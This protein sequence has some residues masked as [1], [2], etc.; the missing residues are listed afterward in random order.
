MKGSS[1]RR[2]G[3]GTP[4]DRLT[5]RQSE[6]CALSPRQQEILEAQRLR[7]DL[8]FA[9]SCYADVTGR[10]DLEILL[11]SIAQ[12]GS[13]FG[14]GSMSLQVAQGVVMN[15]IDSAGAGSIE[16]VDLRAE[17]DSH[18]AAQQWM[19]IDSVRS[20]DPLTDELVTSA[21]LLLG[22]KR[23]FW[24]TRVHPIV[25]D[26]VGMRSMT[27]R[28]AEI[29]T[30]RVRDQ[31]VP[32]SSAKTVRTPIDADEA[33]R[34]SKRW[35]ADQQ[36]WESKLAGAPTRTSLVADTAP[37][38]AMTRRSG[39]T[40][41]AYVATSLER[42]AEA[43]DVSL[44][45]VVLAAFT[46]YLARM[47]GS[48]DVVARVPVSARTSVGAR[49]SGGTAS[50]TVPVRIVVDP[51]STIEEYLHT[52]SSELFGAVRHQKC[53][54]LHLHHGPVLHLNLFPAGVIFG[55]GVGV[56]RMLSNGPVDDL[57]VVLTSLPSAD[58]I[59]IDF[60]A[61]PELYSEES[62][63]TFHRRFIDVLE[64][65]TAAD[66]SIALV[67]VNLL[68][69]SGPSLQHSR[70]LAYWSSVLSSPAPALGLTAMVAGER[71]S[72]YFVVDLDLYRRLELL[73]E[74]MCTSVFVLY[75][76]AVAGVLR[77]A[78]SATE[79]SI[80]TSVRGYGAFN[81]D[82]FVSMFA[83]H[84]VLRLPVD[85]FQ[86]LA[87]LIEQMDDVIVDALIHAD[88]PLSAV[89]QALEDVRSVDTEPLF[90][91]LA[92]A[93]TPTDIHPQFP[94][95]MAGLPV[96]FDLATRP[97]LYVSLPIPRDTDSQRTQS[98]IGTIDG[99]ASQKQIDSLAFGFIRI[100]QAMVNDPST[101]LGAVDLRWTDI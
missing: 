65:F 66:T 10:L 94:A 101:S 52:V 40:V 46:L 43:H 80:G 39:E 7:P 34:G 91:A 21:V 63:T 53:R 86:S 45:T 31:R 49:R 12:A 3:F 72:A 84:L 73:A 97:E 30:A 22:D 55:A 88:V 32:P 42:V 9:V 37:A 35:N 99:L 62:L 48:D 77:R 76:S 26:A 38:V 95:N 96:G 20:L 75:Q 6:L 69:D 68:S 41:S 56:L 58:G 78:G 44:S 27:V 60:A 98:I 89:R 17:A 24:Y 71:S 16:T 33:Y 29:Y 90:R 85:T 59:R 57:E 54:G 8:P 4:P 82:D 15:R 67:D 28:A 13:E 74:S 51:E 14:S 23:W 11:D 70:N 1:G 19:A 61:N 18:E 47:T 87:R 36:Y 81:P 25:L 64:I 2:I 50:N 92:C 79:V 83:N 100:L 93:P 5:S